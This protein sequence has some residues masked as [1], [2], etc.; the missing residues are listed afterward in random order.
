V[1]VRR[2]LARAP[3]E[4]VCVIVDSTGLK[5]CGQGEWH[6][7]KHGEKQGKRWKKLPIG[8]DDQGQMLASTVTESTEQDPSHVPELLDQ[9]DQEIDRF[10]AD[11]MYDQA[12]VYAAVADHSPGV[13]VIIPPRKDAVLSP[14]ARLPPTQRDQH[15]LEIEREGRFA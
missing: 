4:S 5:V 9:I 10:I 14:T 11:G 12:P 15:L 2:T 3:Q 1:A 13:R 8:V 7:Q 6:R